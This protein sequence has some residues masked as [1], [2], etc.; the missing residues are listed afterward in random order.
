MR[1]LPRGWPSGGLWSHPDFLRL[2]GAQIVSAFGS[3]ITRTALPILA[4]LTLQ[5]TP[6]EIALLSALGVAPGLLVGLFMGGHVDRNAKRPLLIGADVV[7]ALLLLTLP[8][9]ARFGTLSMPQLYLVAAAVGA[10]TTL[11]QIADNSYLPTLV[12]KALLVEANAR[13][14]ASESVAEAAGP[15]LA[16]VLV[17]WLTAPVAIGVDALSYVWSALWLGRIRTP[18][19]PAAA[20]GAHVSVLG[21]IVTGFRAC[22]AHPLIRPVLIA[23]AVMYFFGGFF[24]ALYM[25]FTLE[26]LGLTPATVGVIIGVGGVGSFVGAL[27]ARPMV[28]RGLGPAMGISLLV[29]QGA[30]LLIPL[31]REAGAWSIPLLVLQQL[32]GDALLGAYV[33]HAL[34]LRQWVMDSEVLGRANATFHVVTGLLLSLGALLAGPLVGVL[35]MVPTLWIGAGGGLLAVPLLLG[36]SPLT[37]RN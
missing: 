31:A 33:I 30:N 24:L 8:L 15:G 10:A 9:A 19:P 4:L 35:G 28:R 18:E 2:W 17:Q 13:L 27:I 7:R 26:T 11:F 12:D 20:T 22:L 5:A 37:W 29:G 21:D 34:S 36:G 25:V 32:L 16:G 3:R 23:E 1:V 14:E 6:T